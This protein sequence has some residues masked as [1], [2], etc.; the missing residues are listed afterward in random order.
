[1]AEFTITSQKKT[2]EKL[3]A[4]LSSANKFRE[5]YNEAIVDNNRIEG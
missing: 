5:K 2:I 4:D 3:E 1:M